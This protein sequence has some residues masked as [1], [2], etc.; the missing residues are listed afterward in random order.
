[1]QTLPLF[2]S[3]WFQRTRYRYVFYLQ[4]YLSFCNVYF[5]PF[6][7]SVQQQFP[8]SMYLQ[9]LFSFC[10]W[11]WDNQAVSSGK[12]A[13]ENHQSF[14]EGL[15]VPAL[16]SLQAHRSWVKY[17]RASCQSAE[18]MCSWAGIYS[19]WPLSQITNL[20]L[21]ERQV[22]LGRNNTKTF[23]EDTLQG[24][25]AVYSFQGASFRVR[26]EDGSP[27]T[28]RHIFFRWVKTASPL[29]CSHSWSALSSNTCHIKL[30]KIE[31]FWSFHE[32][33][34]VNSF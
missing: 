32:I 9:T 6:F 20:L 13:S 21:T 31:A 2:Y 5:E 18:Q 15:L 33:I 4:S 26:D 19:V 25:N 14:R 8:S 23:E 10:C 3:T 27:G 11:G 28:S 24:L 16:L 30:K 7:I 29:V 12:V 34:G 17:E 22:T 1:M